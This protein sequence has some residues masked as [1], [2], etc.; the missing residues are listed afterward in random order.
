MRTPVGDKVET[1]MNIDVAYFSG[2]GST[3]FVAETF[4]KELVARQHCVRFRK[5]G[6]IDIDHNKSCDLLII[7]FVVHAFNPPKPV[8]DWVRDRRYMRSPSSVII[9]VSGGGE[10]TPNLACREMLKKELEKKG[11]PVCY[12]KMIVMPSNIFLSTKPELTKKLID[13][14]PYKVSFCIS[15]ILRGKT[16]TTD[17]GIVNKMISR[18]GRMEHHA[19]S[20]F[21]KCIQTNENCIGCGLCKKNCPVGNIDLIDHRPA[22]SAKCALCLQCIYGCPRKALAPT[23]WKFIIIKEGYNIEKLVKQSAIGNE[24]DP[25]KEPQ[26]KIWTG[27]RT[28]LLNTTDVREPIE[29]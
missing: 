25:A 10:I 13:I 12:E 23:K 1:I 21:G 29:N 26:G 6:K 17:P 16:K 4:R 24:I 3:R 2:T 9:S 20:K 22:F 11:Y 28:Y 5:I 15:E 18:L 14:L 19:A 8:I 7:C 27:V